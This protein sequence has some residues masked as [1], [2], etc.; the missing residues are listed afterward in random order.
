MPTP[1]TSTSTTL[2]PSWQSLISI[3]GTD[4]L[5]NGRVT[6]PGSAA[7]G[8]LLNSRM[9]QAIFDDENDETVGTWAYP[10]IGR[11]DPERNTS[12]F[13]AALP[14]YAARGLGAFTVNLQGGNPLPEPGGHDQAWVVTAYRADGSLKKPWLSRLERVIRAADQEGMVVI[15][16]FFYFGQDHRLQD[17]AAVLRAADGVTDWLLSQGYTNVLV[18]VNNEANLN[19]NHPILKPKRVA[20][21]IGRIQERSGGR[22]LVSTSFSGGALPPEEVVRQ[23]DFVLLHGNNQSPDRIR[24]MVREIRSLSAYQQDPKP[25]VFN[26]DSTDLRKLE[27]AVQEGVSWGYHDKGKNNY[28]DGFQAPP[29]N[30]GINTAEKQAFFG[31]VAELAAED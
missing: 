29:V 16:G 26:E 27:A 31:R 30:W 23:A 18:E 14:D 24:T 6:S 8:L 11:W 3:S 7:E 20:E 12:E 15:V 21:L 25:I 28:R 19:Y 13:V 4:F 1:T 10:D 5:L 22:L 2:L 17:E 9:V